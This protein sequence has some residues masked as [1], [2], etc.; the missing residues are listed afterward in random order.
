MHR[1]KRLEEN[2]LK[3]IKKGWFPIFNIFSI[4]LNFFNGCIS[5]TLEK[6]K[7]DIGGKEAYDRPKYETSHS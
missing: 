3:C 6:K 5:L 2:V 1:K 4:F 7:F